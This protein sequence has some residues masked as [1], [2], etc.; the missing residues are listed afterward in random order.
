[1]RRFVFAVVVLACAVAH[2]RLGAADAPVNTL[3]WSTEKEQGTYGY[4]VYRAPSDAGPF[5]RINDRV[6][7]A[8]G[9][10]RYTFVDA[11]VVPGQVYFYRIYA[12]STRGFK[13]SLGP[14]VRRET[15]AH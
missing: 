5:R 6:V 2:V 11:A 9:E 7:A 1:M 12:V 4:L 15:A 8:D 13:K 10:G 3:R 14:I